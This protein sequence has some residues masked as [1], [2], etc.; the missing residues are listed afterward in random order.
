METSGFQV[1]RG[2]RMV[3]SIRERKDYIEIQIL[4]SGI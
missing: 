3:T 4:K 1:F 2:Q